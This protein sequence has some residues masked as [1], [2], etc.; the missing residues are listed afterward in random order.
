MGR[1]IQGK[2]FPETDW[3]DGKRAESLRRIRGYVEEEVGE[4]IGWYV[5]KRGG[6]KAMAR[7]LRLAAILL[8]GVG[9]LVP[10]LGKLLV[11][12]DRHPGID[13]LWTAILVGVAG[14]LL[15]L[16]R[17]FGFSSARVRYMRA[18]QQIGERLKDFRLE[19]ERLV[20]GW[21][22]PDATVEQALE[23]LA[24]CRSVILRVDRIVQQETNEWTAEFQ[25]A[26]RQIDATTE[27]ANSGDVGAGEPP[28]A[29]S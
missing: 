19:Y 14:I 25:A 24:L 28:P 23:C 16:D 4:A 13:P 6:K 18:E 1:N 3:S 27:K 21:N 22:A 26:L 8:T 5:D 15:L 2:K 17:F 20:L 10:L 7:M 9:G 12:E 29:G 11:T